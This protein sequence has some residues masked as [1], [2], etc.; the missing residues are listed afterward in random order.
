MKISVLTPSYNS[1]KYLEKA[2]LSVIKQDCPSFEHIVFDGGSTDDTVQVLKKY[3][4]LKWVSESDK[5]QSDAMNKAFAISSGEIIVYLNA[6]DYFAE[7]AFKEVLSAFE[8]YPKT[9]MVVG[10]LYFTTEHGTLTRKPTG[11]YHQIIQYW[12]NRFPNNPV[13]YF[14]RRRVQEEIGLFSID[15]HYSMDV[16]FLLEA[17]KKFKILKIEKVLGTFYSDG[18]NKTALIDSGFYLH[19]TVKSHLKKENS[20]LLLYFYFKLWLAKTTQ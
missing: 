8:S 2:I 11:K 13:S 6:D 9:D 15:N 16:F 20:F 1:G 17:Y 14:Y 3:P 7:G 5:G 12:K 4:H 19:K 18:N 10:N